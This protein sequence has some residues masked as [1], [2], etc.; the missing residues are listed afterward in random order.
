MIL[1]GGDVQEVN[2]NVQS[3]DADIRVHHEVPSGDQKT[4]MMSLKSTVKNLEN[5]HRRCSQINRCMDTTINGLVLLC[6]GTVACLESL[7]SSEVTRH[8]HHVQVSKIFL[9]GFVSVLAA[10]NQLFNNSAKSET[11]HTLC[12]NYMLLGL[13]IDQYIATNEHTK[14]IDLLKE[15]TDTRVGSIGL[16]EFVRNRYGVE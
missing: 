12:R 3:D 7:V 11:H 15:F 16:F 9:S 13:K 8:E 14:Y 1:Q 5:A 10:F 2:V 4:R 6:S